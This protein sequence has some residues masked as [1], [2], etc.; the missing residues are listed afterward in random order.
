MK[1]IILML[2]ATLI[3]SGCSYSYSEVNNPKVSYIGEE[4]SVEGSK[5]TINSEGLTFN[6]TDSITLYSSDSSSINFGPE[7][8]IPESPTDK[9]Y[10]RPAF[11]LKLIPSRSFETIQASQASINGFKLTEYKN[12]NVAEWT[13]TGLCDSAHFEVIGKN[14]NIQIRSQNCD[15]DANAAAYI[16]GFFETSEVVEPVAS[17]AAKQ[18]P[19]D[20]SSCGEFPT[21][22]GD[23]GPTTRY[24]VC[25]TS[26]TGNCYY[27]KTSQEQIPGTDPNFAENPYGDADSFTTVTKAYSFTG[28]PILQKLNEKDFCELTTQDFF[29]TKVK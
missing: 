21:S 10:T 11:L 6:V 15:F 4:F 7:S 25:K 13:D 23:G 9:L 3:L 17:A 28:E 1:K 20:L 2:A 8:Q 18:D 29:E 19:T 22:D 12:F 24:F 5:I 14:Q 27:K 16:K 26:Q